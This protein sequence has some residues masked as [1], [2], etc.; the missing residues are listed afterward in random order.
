[1][2][3]Q[4]FRYDNWYFQV[5]SPG[6]THHFHS[7][8]SELY[9]TKSKVKIKS[10]IKVE[11]DRRA[12]VHSVNKSFIYQLLINLRLKRLGLAFTARFNKLIVSVALDNTVHE[13]I[14]NQ[15]K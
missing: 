9:K 14:Q 6:L 10:V 8:R 13:Q 2:T 3:C 15:K 1:M 7:I 12:I 4:I 11:V 5:T